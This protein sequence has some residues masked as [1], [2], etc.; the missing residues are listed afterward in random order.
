MK[1][2]PRPGGDV[3]SGA[4]R[5]DILKL[6][7]SAI[8]LSVAVSATMAL[9]R[10]DIATP[11]LA[12]SVGPSLVAVST[13]GAAFWVRG[14]ERRT[15]WL[16][17]M[18]ALIFFAGCAVIAL[19]T[20]G[21]IIVHIAAAVALGWAVTSIASQFRLSR[22]ALWLCLLIVGLAYIVIEVDGNKYLNF[23]ADRLLLA[24]RTD[25]DMMFHSSIVSA[26]R[27]FGFPSSG[28]DGLHLIRYHVGVDATAALLS[29]GIDVSS[30]LALMIL[31][32]EILYPLMVFAAAS[33]AMAI[34]RV[35]MPLQRFPAINFA[36]GAVCGVLMLQRTVAGNL[37][38]A[39]DPL[40][41]SG[42]I[43]LFIAPTVMVLLSEPRTTQARHGAWWLAILVIPVLSL[44]KI[45]TGFVWTGMIAWWALRRYGLRNRAFWVIAIATAALFLPCYWLFSNPDAAHAVL[46]GTPYLVARGF[47][48]GNYLLPLRV[49]AQAL[50]ALLWLWAWRRNLNPAPFRFQV[51]TLVVAI[52]VGLLPGLLMQIPDANAYFFIAVVA[53]L[54]TPVLVALIASLPLHLVQPATR[55]WIV[56][57]ASALAAIGI[58]VNTAV[59]LPT[60]INIVL[61]SNALI[62]TGDRSF[63]DHDSRRGWR[64]DAKRARK[65]YGV[66]GL[67]RLAPPTPIGVGL[68]DALQS[69]KAETGATG[70][71]YIPPVSDYWSLT[72]DCDGQ[73][74]WPMAVAGV[75]LIDGYVPVQAKCPQYPALNGYGTPPA[76]RQ[77]LSDQ[78]ICSRA[79]AAGFNTVLRIQSLTDRTEDRR[80]TCR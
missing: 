18:T 40:L 31:R 10:I 72:T 48:K 42:V 6:G 47:A 70:A 26:F 3:S 20:I 37:S 16:G 78:E 19:G 29:R 30:I 15:L 68:A 58:L 35:L 28:I 27:Y 64:E 60:P 57:T 61:A 51:E 2:Q 1:G 45:S 77:D 14:N 25:G 46:F 5:D 63:Y 8:A 17:P 54:S 34:G 22:A 36:A 67:F 65:Q 44:A 23:I 4:D 79:L 11:L 53:W 33:G 62:R 12:L 21:V 66:I 74:T 55:R 75:P 9:F 52:V 24:G 49:H 80:L 56:R 39:N 59:L 50:V 38:N 43:L 71:A 13:L 41:F 73:S 7:T 76:V 32:A 69:F